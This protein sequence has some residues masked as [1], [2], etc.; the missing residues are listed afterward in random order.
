LGF[1]ACKNRLRYGL[2]K[3]YSLTRATSYT[4]FGPPLSY[5]E[6]SVNSCRQF[7]CKSAAA[8]ACTSFIYA[9]VDNRLVRLTVSTAAN[10]H[11]I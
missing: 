8:V 6:F 4:V 2:V 9:H 7:R 10:Y 3:P 11:S 5:P 1:V